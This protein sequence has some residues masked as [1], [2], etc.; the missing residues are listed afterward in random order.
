MSNKKM[1]MIGNAHIDPVWFWRWQE[2]FQEIK[3]TFRSVLDRMKEFDDFVFTCSSA[4]FYEWIEQNEPDMFQE[5]VQRVKEGRWIL[6]GG[7]WVQPDCNAPSGEGFVRQGL[8]GQRYFASRFGKTARSGYNIDSFGHN[9]MLPQIL[10]KQGLENYVFMRPGWHEK[11]IEGE[12]FVW[13]AKD[14]SSVLAYR[15]PYEYCTWPDQ[16]EAHVER[17][18]GLLKEDDDMLMCFY[19]VGNH[20]GG[21]T[22]RNLESIHEMNG[23]E[24]F[25][26]L[27]LS[28]PDDYFDEVRKRGRSLPAA[29]GEL[30]HHASGCYSAGM[31]L[32]AANRITENRLIAAEK[33]SAAAS[34][35]TGFPYPADELTKAWKA[36]LFNQFHDTL[37][38]TAVKS[39]YE[40]ALEDYG[41]ALYIADHCLNAAAQR[42]SWRVQIPK[43]EGMKPF[44]VFNTNGYDIRQAVE[45]EMY[46]PAGTA[47]LSD[48][49]GNEIPYQ[50]IQS[51]ASSNGR[52]RMCFVAELPALGYMTCF[53]RTKEGEQT[54]ALTEQEASS[55][56]V[57]ENEALSV[58]VDEKSGYIRSFVNKKD[59]TEYFSDAA[60]VP[61]VIRDTSDTWSH[62]K[63]IFDDVC[64]E[65]SAVSVRC[66]E[67]GPVR[68]VI[69]AEYVYGNSALSQDFILY[70]NLDYV[71]VHA[72]LDW[73]ETHSMLK[74]KF[75]LQM[76]YLKWTCQVPHGTAGREP[77]G[78]E[79]PV[80]HFMDFEGAAPG[81]ETGISGLSIMTDICSACSTANKDAYITVLRSPIY[82]NHDPY[83]P[84]GDIEY[85]YI[86]QGVTEF[87][88]I[89]YPHSGSYTACNTVKTANA[90]L[91]K[92][93]AVAETYHDGPFA[94][95]ASFMRIDSE[96]V[97]LH[98]VKLSEDGQGDLVVRV[99]ETAGM[100]GTFT[101]HIPSLNY[102]RCFDI[103]SAEIKTLRI[104]VRDGDTSE[105]LM[106]EL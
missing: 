95:T 50:M 2:G 88:Y 15:V 47:V 26:E 44:V 9:G 28:N 17:C 104:N 6:A 13:R 105:I 20:G 51:E 103:K 53:L 74:I 38:G 57:L 87:E 31:K 64:G 79:Y 58:T 36:V 77:N 73:H 69:R 45:I 67:D 61:V 75:P 101:L 66:A 41:Y 18:A 37:A 30:L 68:K 52:S 55:G 82:A 81:M 49:H 92:P 83:V 35:L 11:H 7:W 70:K 21:P 54:A 85:S 91:Q 3:A 89:L 96:H 93:F 106:T 71:C 94:Q 34:V 43:E 62:G 59:G 98:V 56:C 97:L 33:L 42:I 46:T 16:I 24:G 32:K 12:T 8:Y 40:D 19:G 1:Y 29:D 39:A 23:R 63:L 22:I 72:R 78:Q 10:K 48:C 84:R 27:I 76:N 86:D 25:P 14:G 5:I 60:A 99:Y 4:A 65:F 90:I 102:E 80:Q 100:D